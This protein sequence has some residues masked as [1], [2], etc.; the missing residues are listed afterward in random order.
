[1]IPCL[2][3]STAAESAQTPWTQKHKLKHIRV[4]S[5]G[6]EREQAQQAAE[7]GDGKWTLHLTWTRLSRDCRVLAKV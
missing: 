3:A 7:F 6:R 1:M 5:A 4:P 2:S